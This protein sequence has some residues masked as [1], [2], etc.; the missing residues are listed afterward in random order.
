MIRFALVVASTLGFVLTAALGNL[1]VPML[2]ELERSRQR[3]EDPAAPEQ[4]PAL[5]GLCLMVGT[6][7]A[8][9][10]GWVAACAA[11]PDLLG[12]D[13]QYVGRLL[14]ALLGAALFG[15]VGLWDDLLRLG[16]PGGLGLRRLPRLGLEAAA[17]AVVE[18]LLAAKGCL[19]TGTVLPGGGYLELG[20]A[21]PL[22]W[23]LVLVALAEC[24]RVADGADG[25][26]C[27][28]AFVA[29]L[30]L[31][32]LATR[33]GWF[34]LA[35]LPAALAGA[36]MAFLLWNFPPRKAPPGALRQP[37]PCRGSGLH[38]PVH[39]LWGAGGAFGAASV[40]RGCHDGAAA[41]GCPLCRQT[42]VP[43]RP[44]APVAGK[45]GL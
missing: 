32:M 40:G 8:V 28:T 2:R 22:V 43:C 29:M 7:A 12:T 41:A 6:L 24:G 20:A 15:A 45:T 14:T 17:A 18:L 37:V 36:L 42:P 35:V 23:G 1:M 4:P 13:A 33:L 30:G 3:R 5:G 31:M 34:P 19:P 9:G 44:P 39:G 11:Q 38:P 27:G 21:A 10:V 26:V 16:S 25:T